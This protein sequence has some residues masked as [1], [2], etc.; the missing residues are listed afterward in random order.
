M[1]DL[2]PG[3]GR[4]GGELVA[5]G[6]P[7]EVMHNPDSLTGK[8]ISGKVQIEMRPERRH[9]NGNALPSSAPKRTTSSISMSPSHWA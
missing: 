5:S 1:I 7:D 2:G 9:T 4:H 8:Y 6:T 3:A